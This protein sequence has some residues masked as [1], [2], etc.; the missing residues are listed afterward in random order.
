MAQNFIECARDQSFLLPPDVRDWL[1]EGHF[2]WFVLDAVAEMDLGSWYDV[3][4]CDGQGRPA[5]DPSMMGRI[6]PVVATLKLRSCDAEEKPCSRSCRRGGDA[7][8]RTPA[9]WAQG[10]SGPVLGGDRSGSV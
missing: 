7:W 1:P 9:C 2:A 10:T 6:Q 5:Y 4:R 8:R 3:Y